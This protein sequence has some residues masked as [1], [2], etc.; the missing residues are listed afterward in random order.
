[1]NKAAQGS[2]YIGKLD[3]TAGEESQYRSEEFELRIF[4]GGYQRLDAAINEHSSGEGH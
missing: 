2:Y 4:K 3:T 1:M